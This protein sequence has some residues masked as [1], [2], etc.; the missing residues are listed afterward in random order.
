M[1]Y[2]SLTVQLQI[3][4][5]I[6]ALCRSDLGH[7]LA[8]LVRRTSYLARVDLHDFKGPSTA[9]SQTRTRSVL[10]IINFCFDLN[11]SLPSVFAT[12]TRHWSNQSADINFGRI[13]LSILY[14][15]AF[16]HVRRRSS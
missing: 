7:M 12:A 14:F 9:R 16:V 3:F 15:R 5:F 4:D 2:P 6:R 13:F 10:P 1:F 8:T 11:R